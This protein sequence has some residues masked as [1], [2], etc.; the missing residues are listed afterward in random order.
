MANSTPKFDDAGFIL[1]SDAQAEAEESPLFA[2]MRKQFNR[3]HLA[4]TAD[5]DGVLSR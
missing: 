1:S 2:K 3:E 4:R 5:L